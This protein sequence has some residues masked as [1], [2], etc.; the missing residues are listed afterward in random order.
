MVLNVVERCM[1]VTQ[2]LVVRKINLV[3]GFAP[4][5]YFYTFF[6]YQWDCWKVCIGAFD[7][8]QS[9]FSLLDSAHNELIGPHLYN[10]FLNPTNAI[11]LATRFYR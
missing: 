2:M 7:D 10:H 4:A 6:K 5:V 11:P 9:H 1:Y 8:P 3:C